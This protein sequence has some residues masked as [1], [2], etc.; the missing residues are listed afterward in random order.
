MITS[1]DVD[2]ASIAVGGVVVLSGAASDPDTP[3]LSYSWTATSGRIASPN[4]AETTFRCDAPGNV[5]LMFTA[6]D[7]RCTDSVTTLVQCLPC[8]D[9]AG[10]GSNAGH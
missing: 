8:A 6:S 5:S 2:P 3:N 10:C 9:D 7:G 1:Y 4:A